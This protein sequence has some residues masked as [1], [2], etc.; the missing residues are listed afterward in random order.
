MNK[1]EL[2]KEA[3][4]ELFPF[5][6]RIPATGDFALAVTGSH[7]RGTADDGSDYDLCLFCEAL[8]P[9]DVLRP[10][11]GEI[12]ML[13]DKWKECGVIIDGPLPR[14]YA[15]M[16][17]QLD[18]WMSGKAEPVPYVWT[19]WGYHILVHT[20]ILTI[21][22]DPENKVAAWLERLSVYPDAL[23][24][25]VIKKHA[26]SLRYWK[27]DY[28]YQNKVRRE[29]VVFLSSI[30]ARLIHDIMQVLY[31]LNRAYYPGDGNN[32][33]LARDFTLKPDDLEAKVTAILLPAKNIGGFA[34]Q[35]EN[36]I[37]LIDE[38]LQIA[39]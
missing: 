13:T 1:N 25:A 7:G 24:D 6:Q 4:D 16:D 29:D 31:A 17:D 26:G 20:S 22:Y 39:G 34:E 3:I 8:A 12:R 23:R 35:Y 15:D 21:L 30:T 10:V 2:F 38:V 18:L 19:V 9:R 5:M 14:T 36:L 37:K 11:F 28:H 32:L 33:D 27:D